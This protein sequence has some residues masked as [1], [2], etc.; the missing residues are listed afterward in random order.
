MNENSCLY[1]LAFVIQ[2]TSIGG[3]NILNTQLISEILELTSGKGER[4]PV[5]LAKFIPIRPYHSHPALPPIHCWADCA[6]I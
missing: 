6:P 3:E 1:A 2:R 4:I 5:L